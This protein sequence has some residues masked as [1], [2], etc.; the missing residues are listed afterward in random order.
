M[1]A[2]QM[3][4]A[5]PSPANGLTDI[6]GLRSI[7]IVQPKGKRLTYGDRRISR[8]DWIFLLPFPYKPED[9]GCTTHP[10]P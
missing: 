3:S 7:F 5:F 2:D 4:S 1:K 6:G 8:F 10:L 9:D